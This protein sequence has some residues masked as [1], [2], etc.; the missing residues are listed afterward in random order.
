MDIEQS[1]FVPTRNCIDM[2]ISTQD[3]EKRVTTQLI[4]YAPIIIQSVKNQLLL[5]SN[6]DIFVTWYQVI[7]FLSFII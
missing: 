1:V 2:L 3:S 5:K 7:S 6:Q 4:V